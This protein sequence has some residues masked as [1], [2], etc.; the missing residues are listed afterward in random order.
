MAFFK[1][2][3][4]LLQ[5]NTCFQLDHDVFAC[6][7]S[8]NFKRDK[9]LRACIRILNPNTHRSLSPNSHL[10]LLDIHTQA[11]KNRTG[12]LLIPNIRIEGSL[13]LVSKCRPERTNF[14]I[15]RYF[16]ARQGM[17]N[18]KKRLWSSFLVQILKFQIENAFT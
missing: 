18:C 10:A 5:F 1:I 13:H 2:A 12:G 6:L 11:T 16:I 7:H 15:F 14:V 4:F 8:T 9:D 3:I 17:L